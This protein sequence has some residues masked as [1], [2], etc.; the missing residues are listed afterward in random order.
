MRSASARR[1]PS[2]PALTATAHML[3]PLASLTM[4]ARAW[5]ATAG[6]MARGSRMGCECAQMMG[7]VSSGIRSATAQRV[8]M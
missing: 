1:D 7:S 6:T 3:A 8:K 4:A 5:R 2:N